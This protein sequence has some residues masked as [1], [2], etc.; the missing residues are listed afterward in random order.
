MTAQRK[1]RALLTIRFLIVL[2]S[3]ASILVVAISVLGL[4]FHSQREILINGALNYNY[5][6]ATKM[7]S[8]IDDFL[9]AA[10]N[11]LRF[12]ARAISQNF[13]DRSTLEREASRL[14]E[15]DN[16][17]NSVVIV[18]DESEV[19]ATN[20][21]LGITGRRL[22]SEN[23]RILQEGRTP[24]ISAPFMATTGRLL[25]SISQ[26]VFNDNDRYLGYI[27]GTIYL[28]QPSILNRILADHFYRDDSYVY[29][30]DTTRRIIYHPDPT[31]IGEVVET[32]DAIN[33]T[34][35]GKDGAQRLVNSV[36][37]D[38]LA[39]FAIVPDLGWGVVAQSPTRSVL[40]PLKEL[41][42]RL[43]YYSL[44]LLILVAGLIWLF[45]SLISRP[46]TR[47]ADCAESLSENRSIEQI[48]T[49][50]A[51]YFELARL[52]EALLLGATLANEHI[53]KLR[54]D[55]RTDGLT[56]L[57]NRREFDRTLE[58]W[59]GVKYQGSLITLD[60]DHFKQINDTYGH[61]VGDTVLQQVARMIRSFSR[62]ADKTF[63]IG[64]EEF[65]IL[66]A[67][68]GPSAAHEIAE[69]LRREIEST[70]IAP[71]G[72]ITVS[73]GVAHWPTHVTELSKL[74]KQADLMLYAAKRNG[75]NRVEMAPDATRS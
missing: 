27:S 64:G 47:L 21:E 25:I 71:A 23:N 61:D 65:A 38:M 9:L 40:Q 72:R 70:T 59:R 28:E 58:A 53:G 48:R 75:R 19:L 35:A 43:F 50:P 55:V 16:S 29:A 6:Y 33:S 36:G 15:Q 18:D 39:G 4:S 51:W 42:A 56:G 3:V 54:H 7:A 17:F 20:P 10:Q 63:R 32:N 34:V 60:I 1:Q 46:L 62:D 52:R 24:F 37:V 41:N 67:E 66:L 26:P 30:F 13:S 8:S 74:P 22:T 69:R 73:L 44:P 2:L 5:A 14:R 68:T 45:S 49:T 12:S 11:K 31:R 57:L